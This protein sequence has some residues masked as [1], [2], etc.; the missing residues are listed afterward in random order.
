MDMAIGG[1][2]TLAI[3]ASKRFRPH[4]RYT[5]APLVSTKHDLINLTMKA[6]PTSESRTQTRK[7]K[8]QGFK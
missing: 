7:D 8:H 2:S 3:L 5:T 6:F 1:D 4:N